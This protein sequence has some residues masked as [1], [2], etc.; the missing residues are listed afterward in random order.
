MNTGQ[1]THRDAADTRKGSNLKQE[2]IRP[3]PPEPGLHGLRIDSQQRFE[4]LTEVLGGVHGALTDI[5]ADAE[6]LGGLVQE[7]G[8]ARSDAGSLRKSCIELVDRLGR[9]HAALAS[10]R[11]P[12][13]LARGLDAVGE[14]RSECRQLRAVAS[15][16]RVA[17]RSANIDGIEDYIGSLRKMIQRL[18]DTTVVVHEGLSRINSSTRDAASLLGDASQCARAALDRQR[19]AAPEGGDD[20]L[21][22]MSALAARLA[23]STSRN[24]GVLMNGIQFSDAFA[25]RLQHVEAIIDAAGDRPAPAV[26]AS[27]QLRAL[28]ADAD[29]LI[30]ETRAAL[31]SLA[32]DGRSA[33]QALAG[34]IGGKAAGMLAGWHRELDDGRQ[35]DLLV[36]PA[37]RS[38]VSAVTAIEVAM[39]GA[40]RDLATLATTA[41]EV[42]LAA[43]NSGLL[44]R[45]SGNGKTAMAV[46]SATVQERAHACST[47]NLRCRDSFA[48]ISQQTTGADF[49]QLARQADA[50]GIQLARA[51]A[52]LSRA[53]ALLSQL[54]D[55]KVAAQAGAADLQRGVEQGLA[56][57]CG[58]PDLVRQIGS[59]AGS[60]Q[61]PL[62][63]AERAEI[64]AFADLYTMEREREIHAE[65]AGIALAPMAAAQQS[66]DDIFF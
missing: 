18:E 47:L 50:L 19:D 14:M 22:V 46:L 9:A 62:S 35:L 42:R 25:Q 58:L 60:T 44:A 39:E 48:V 13:A 64:D 65:V 40:A 29:V 27:A 21:P 17:G 30:A 57:L 7:V 10:D 33:A 12:K 26:L 59:R 61:R 38:A 34:D 2:I 52:D 55:L 24:T 43:I 5:A 15:M 66:L 31:Q 51:K 63:D 54:E 37:L 11:L 1:V 41:Q 3:A 36:T 8:A 32:A 16:T 53:T 28:R 4:Q 6:R 56:V 45:R 20:L 49:A 23:A